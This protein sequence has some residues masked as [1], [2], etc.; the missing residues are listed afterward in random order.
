MVIWCRKFIPF[1]SQIQDDAER[2][3]DLLHSRRR[4]VAEFASQASEVHHPYLFRQGNGVLG[5]PP[6]ACRHQYMTR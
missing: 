3:I 1:F 4:K 5:Q 2:I 6:F